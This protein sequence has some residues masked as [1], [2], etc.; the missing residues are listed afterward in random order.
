MRKVTIV[1]VEIRISSRLGHEQIERWVVFG[2]D[3]FGPF[4]YFSTLNQAM[5]KEEVSSILSKREYEEI[6][7]NPKQITLICNVTVVSH[8][9]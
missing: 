6:Y 3:L 9:M 2:I 1:Y 7:S 8:C 4:D 5:I